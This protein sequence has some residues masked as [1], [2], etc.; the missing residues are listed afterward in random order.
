M[1]VFPPLSESAVTISGIAINGCFVQSQ[2]FAYRISRYPKGY[3]DLADRTT[4][5]LV[6]HRFDFD[7]PVVGQFS[8]PLTTV[9]APIVI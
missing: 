4:P 5:P 8:W 9:T 3:R 6:I 2:V 7:W 1:T